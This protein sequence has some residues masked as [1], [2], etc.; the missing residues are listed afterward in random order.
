MIEE[1]NKPIL[2]TDSAGE[3][4]EI[5]SEK[6]ETPSIRF[7]LI[8]IG[9]S[10]VG[11]SCLTIRATHNKFEDITNS[12]IGFEYTTVSFIK[13]P[14]VIIE[15]QI[16]DTCGLERYRSLITNFYHNATLAILVYSINK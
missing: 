10:G 4:W 2:V 13:R 12:T 16:W 9:E 11:K 7:K 3:V 1:N 14:D 15:L 5:S 6:P 8:I